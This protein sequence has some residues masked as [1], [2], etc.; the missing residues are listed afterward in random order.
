MLN[1]NTFYNKWANKSTYQDNKLAGIISVNKQVYNI[2]H[3]DLYTVIADVWQIPTL[4][5]W[6]YDEK[7]R[8]KFYREAKKAGLNRLKD[9]KNEW[10]KIIELKE[11]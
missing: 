6:G 11:L 1:Y 7:K 10:Y 3:L 2:P 4:Y 5:G 9:R 8:N